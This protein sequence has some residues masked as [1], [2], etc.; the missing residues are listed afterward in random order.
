MTNTRLWP[1]DPQAFGRM[2]DFFLLEKMLY[3][4]EYDLAHRPNWLPI[5]LTGMLR[6]LSQ[7]TSEA[8]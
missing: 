2:L 3:E 4:I 7:R 1:R 6:L 5:P 8:L